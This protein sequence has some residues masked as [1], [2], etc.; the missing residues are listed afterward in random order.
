MKKDLEVHDVYSAFCLKISAMMAH[1]FKL[2]TL[3]ATTHSGLYELNKTSCSLLLTSEAA[4]ALSEDDICHTSD[5]VHSASI[6]NIQA[7]ESVNFTAETE[8]PASADFRDVEHAI[9]LADRDNHCIHL[10]DLNAMTHQIF[11]GECGT[12]G[13]IPAAGALLGNVLLY[14]PS[15]VKYLNGA[16]NSAV[17]GETKTY[18]SVSVYR[19]CFSDNFHDEGC[20]T[21]CNLK[22]HDSWYWSYVACAVDGVTLPNTANGI[23]KAVYLFDSEELIYYFWHNYDYLTMIHKDPNIQLT[24]SI[25]SIAFI[26]QTAFFINNNG[27]LFRSNMTEKIGAGSLYKDSKI[28]SHYNGKALRE[29]YSILKSHTSESII[30]YHQNFNEIHEL[31]IRMTP[32]A[33]FSPRYVVNIISWVRPSRL[34]SV[35]TLY[36]GERPCN[37]VS[38]VSYLGTNLESCTYSC[39][40]AEFCTSFSYDSLGECKLFDGFMEESDGFISPCNVAPGTIC[41]AMTSTNQSSEG[42][43]V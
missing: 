13:T 19:P 4:D 7:I 14:Y 20:N 22:A 12:P 33:Q 18:G 41:Y 8:L 25:G 24:S 6:I 37:Q 39:V 3:L 10:F 43:N 15:D 23:V 17:Y 9:L 21:W 40:K 29:G 28:R 35:R 5:A 31:V 2:D 1:P 36:L 11:M 30:A 27:R 26:N 38:F 16:Q 34:K 32:E 42:G